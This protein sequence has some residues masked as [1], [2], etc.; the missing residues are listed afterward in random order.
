MTIRCLS[1]DHLS[2]RNG[3]SADVRTF[4]DPPFP[5]AFPRRLNV[6][7]IAPIFAL[8]LAGTLAGVSQAQDA[9]TDTGMTNERHDRAIDYIEFPV[10]DMQASKAFYS[11]VFGWEF[12][13]YGPDYASF[14]DANVEGGFRQ[15]SEIKAGGPL[16]VFYAEDLE[17]VERSVRGAGGTVIREIFSFPGGRRFHFTDP[18]GNELAVWSDK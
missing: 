12:V 17:G 2:D 1:N 7:R 18:S 13:D 11:A 5:G 6:G 14:S 15:E 8:L 9:E 4:R 3:D 10:T 16:V